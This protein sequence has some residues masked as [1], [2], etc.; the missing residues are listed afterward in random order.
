ML[1]RSPDQKVHSGISVHIRSAS[2]LK[3]DRQRVEEALPPRPADLQLAVAHPEGIAV[4]FIY[5]MQIDQK[6]VC[7]S[8]QSGFQPGAPAFPPRFLMIP[9]TPGPRSPCGTPP[10]ACSPRHSRCCLCRSGRGR[11]GFSR[12]RRG[13]A[14]PCRGH[15]PVKAQ[16]KGTVSDGL[17]NIVAGAHLI[18]V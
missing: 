2:R 6:T 9:R 18:A 11:S 16:C 14:C 12:E 8:G 1:S 13:A 10:D 5:I 15:R 17:Q 7:C 3:E 4:D